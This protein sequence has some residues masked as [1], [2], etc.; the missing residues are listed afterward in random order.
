MIGRARVASAASVLLL[1]V[2]AIAAD[3]SF[4]TDVTGGIGYSRRPFSGRTAGGSSSGTGFYE[5]AVRPRMDVRTATSTLSLTGQATYQDFFGDY[6]SV[7]SYGAGLGYDTRLTERLSAGARLSYDSS[8]LGAFNGQFAGAPIGVPGQ[9]GVIVMPIDPGIPLD[10]GVIVPP[11]LGLFGTGSRRELLSGS[12]NVGYVL[13]QRDSVSL[14]GFYSDA[15]F[16]RFQGLGDYQSYGGTAGYQRRLSETLSLGL[17]GSASRNL[18][19]ETRGDSNIQSVQGTVNWQINQRWSLTGGAGA[20]F[21]Q[22]KAGQLLVGQQTASNSSIASGNLRLCGRGEFDSLCGS[23]SRG[24][25]PTA[26]A[27]TQTQTSFGLSYSRQLDG[28]STIGADASYT[29]NSGRNVIATVPSGIAGDYM[30]GNLS[31][32]RQFGQRLRAIA[33][34]YYRHVDNIGNAAAAGLGSDYGGR[35]GFGYSFGDAR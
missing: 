9:D 1:A 6:Q 7:D 24:A 11:D 34:T 18:F 23:I 30:F 21:F 14:S 17:Q 2:P 5:G 10:P 31:Y 22:T 25:A 12:A 3:T 4:V 8:V 20:T 28:R 35:F 33:S 19:D 26:F 13:S 16:G 29:R 27:G 32:S 15:R